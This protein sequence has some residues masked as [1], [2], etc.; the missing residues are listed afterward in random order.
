MASTITARGRAH[1]ELGGDHLD[2]P[3]RAFMTQGV[4]TLVEDASVRQACGAMV[5]HRVHAVLVVGRVHG[6]PLGWVTSGGLLPYLQRDEASIAVRDAISE[7]PRTIEPS[8]T[9]RE[10][11]AALMGPETTHLLVTPRGAAAAEGVVSA[12]DLMVVANSEEDDR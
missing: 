12:L 8:A 7:E 9:A 11:L 1:D 4:V 5:G 3:V 6:T 2:L 10:A